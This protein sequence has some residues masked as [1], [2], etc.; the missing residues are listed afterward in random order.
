MRRWSE[1]AIRTWGSPAQF[2]SKPDFPRRSTVKLLIVDDDPQI[3]SYVQRL[4][5][6]QGSECMT[7]RAAGEALD[8]LE[9]TDS[10]FDVI[11]LD[12]S[13][14]GRSGWEILD[15]LRAGGDETPVIFLTGH[16]AVEERV[17]GLELG[18]DDYIIKP[19]AA[20]ELLARVDAVVRRRQSLPVLE[21][22]DL[23]LDL[24]RRIA[25]R[26]EQRVDVSPREFDLLRTL[27]EA[28]G[29][30]LSRAQLLRDVWDLKFDP[31]TKVVEVQVARL[32]RKLD[33][34]GPPMIQTLVGEGYRI[35]AP[36]NSPS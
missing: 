17:K 30:V 33:R 21:V 34:T 32:R 14:P 11:L 31:G 25:T 27:M 23:R 29:G 8:I 1:G 24:G 2:S 6:G 12:V 35:H 3:L 13:L 15:E 9:K 5:E 19:F 7:A 22:G 4:L 10:P 26:G 18:A 36:E 20:S 16:H 28:R